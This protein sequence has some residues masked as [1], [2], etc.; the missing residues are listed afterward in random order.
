MPDSD[1]DRVELDQPVQEVTQ[2]EGERDPGLLADPKQSAEGILDD[3]DPEKF[4]DA[5]L[6]AAEET[7]LADEEDEGEAASGPPVSRHVR[8]ALK[9]AVSQK[10]IRET[11]QGRNCNP[12]SKY[13]GFGCQFWCA[14]FVSFCLAK[15]SNQDKKVP[16]IPPG[17]SE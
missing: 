2:E 16:G 12:Y 4:I 10:G 5:E 8:R 15:T 7:V 13:F 14:D 6:E 3:E 9:L 17:W 1:D 11:P